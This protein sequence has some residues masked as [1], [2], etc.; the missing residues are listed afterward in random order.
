MQI[1]RKSLARYPLWVVEFRTI[2]ERPQL[3]YR[4]CVQADSRLSAMQQA[5]EELRQVEPVRD[6]RA[7]VSRV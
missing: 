7:I 1:K 4:Y 3:M 2:G 6:F 5:G